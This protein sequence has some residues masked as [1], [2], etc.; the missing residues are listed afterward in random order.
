MT[1]H[2]L[3]TT[4]IAK[5]YGPVIALRSVDLG[6]APGQIHA[7]LGANGAGKSTMLKIMAG[8]E[9]PMGWAFKSAAQNT[10]GCQHLSQELA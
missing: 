5:S 8:L 9:K 10:S 2:L 6:V 3:Q 7:L 1:A 4:A